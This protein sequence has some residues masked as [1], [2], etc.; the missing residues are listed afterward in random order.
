MVYELKGGICSEGV[1]RGRGWAAKGGGVKWFKKFVL[2]HSYTIVGN[3]F[4]GVTMNYKLSCK[5]GKVL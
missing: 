4:R 2:L 1:K 3:L 5:G